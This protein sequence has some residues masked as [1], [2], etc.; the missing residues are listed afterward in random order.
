MPHHSPVQIT[1]GGQCAVGEADR[2]GIVN[3]AGIGID[4]DQ[5][6]AQRFAESAYARNGGAGAE[7][8][9]HGPVGSGQSGGKALL[10]PRGAF[11]NP[12]PVVEHQD[13]GPC[14]AAASR[15][16]WQWRSHETTGFVYLKRLDVREPQSV[17]AW[18][19][20][21]QPV[22][23]SVALDNPICRQTGVL[24]MS[25][26][27]TGEHEPTMRFGRHPFHRNAVA[28]VWGRPAIEIETMTIK[29][30][31]AARV[32]AERGGVGNFAE[33]DPLALQGG[34]GAPNP[35][36]PRKSGRPESTPMP[37]PAVMSNASLSRSSLAA[38]DIS[39]SGGVLIEIVSHGKA[40]RQR[41]C[42]AIGNR[43]LLRN[44]WEALR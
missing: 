7:F 36:R 10:L 3:F 32:G 8:D 27:I 28:G 12:L 22:D 25:G 41:N 24:E 35:R 11:C 13:I 20:T 16:P 44:P 15:T 1:Q 17:M 38:R 31:G 9:D 5:G 30:P 14:Q 23:R 4:S 42:R 39:G 19:E 37:A 26:D 34:I 21:L 2:G 18:G 43:L 40:R 29:T 33:A 6:Q